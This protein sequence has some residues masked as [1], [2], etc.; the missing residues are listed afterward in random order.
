MNDRK[1]PIKPTGTTG[2]VTIISGSS[3][4]TAEFR[5]LKF[6]T[7][8]EDIEKFIVN[9]FLK[10]AATLNFL[11]QAVVSASQNDQANF[12][13]SLKLTGGGTKSLE[14]M[15]IAPLENLRGSYAIAPASYK[16]YDFARFIFEKLMAKSQR[17]KASNQ[18]GLILLVYVTDWHFVLSQTVTAL[19]QYWTCHTEH[20]FEAIYCYSP[21][22]EGTGVAEL[23]YPTPKEFWATF[24]PD[25]YKENVVVN[26]S[27]AE[28][29]PG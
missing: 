19:L 5:K 16:P 2:P 21:I 15:E 25:S 9:E 8:K 14:L 7:T 4:A 22:D 28:W 1:K 11:P 3:G 10:A 6:P 18:G 17:Y 20:S 23:I 29:T 26:L 13:F 24:N 12:D 27:P